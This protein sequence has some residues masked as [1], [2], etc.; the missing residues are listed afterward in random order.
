MHTCAL[1]QRRVPAMPGTVYILTSHVCRD[2][3]GAP[4]PNSG[5]EGGR[6]DRIPPG[7]R[8]R[9]VQFRASWVDHLD[10]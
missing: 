2:L 10:I 8:D 3:R 7:V 6:L 9:L 1:C 4:V 5:V